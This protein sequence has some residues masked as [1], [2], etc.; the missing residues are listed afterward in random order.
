M[1]YIIAYKQPYYPHFTE[2]KAKAYGL[3]KC[4]PDYAASGNNEYANTLNWHLTTRLLSYYKRFIPKCAVCW[5]DHTSGMVSRWASSPGVWSPFCP[6]AHNHTPEILRLQSSIGALWL[7]SLFQ[8]TASPSFQEWSHFSPQKAIFR[9]FFFWH[10]EVLPW[11]LKMWVWKEQY[12]L[13]SSR[14]L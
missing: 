7:K 3:N 5:T 11:R 2:G 1:T 14:A 6:L 4:T 8:G 12:L 9:L 13:T 10:L